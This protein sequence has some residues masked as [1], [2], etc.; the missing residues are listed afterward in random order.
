[1]QELQEPLEGLL[2]SLEPIPDSK[3]AVVAALADEAVREDESPFLE[4]AM[5]PT[6]AAW[7]ETLVNKFTDSVPYRYLGGLATHPVEADVSIGID[8]GDFVVWQ[9]QSQF[10]MARVT[11]WSVIAVSTFVEDVSILRNTWGIGFGNVFTWIFRMVL[12]IWAWTGAR[13]RMAE[14]GIDRYI[15]ELGLKPVV[16]TLVQPEPAV[17]GSLAVLD[18]LRRDGLIT[19]EEYARKRVEILDRL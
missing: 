2:E 10:S 8:S 9:P 4:L 11:P 5:A 17:R 1:L 3:P 19:D 18:G 16:E 13:T 12:A 6:R 7:A 15:D 14:I